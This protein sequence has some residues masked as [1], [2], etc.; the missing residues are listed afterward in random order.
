M[1]LYK[2]LTKEEK[3]II[4]YKSMKEYWSIYIEIYKSPKV[5]RFNK[6]GEKLLKTI[7]THKACVFWINHKHEELIKEKN[8]E[9][10]K[11]TKIIQK[12]AK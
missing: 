7:E 1:N 9:I 12:R 3:R 11:L 4:D 5:E 6:M 10:K 2:E 8:E